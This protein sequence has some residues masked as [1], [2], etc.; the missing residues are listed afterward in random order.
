MVNA[1]KPTS[2]KSKSNV[3]NILEEKIEIEEMKDK[4]AGLENVFSLRFI[5]F[6]VIPEGIIFMY[7]SGKSLSKNV[8][9]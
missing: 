7:C 3:F 5:S 8:F 6:N 4:S 9:E 1:I 2:P